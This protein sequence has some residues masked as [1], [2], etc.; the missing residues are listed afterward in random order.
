MIWRPYRDSTTVGSLGSEEGEIVLDEEGDGGAR[1]TLENPAKPGG[2]HTI[3]CGIYGAM[4]HT[5]FFG[6]EDEA[7]KAWEPM[8]TELAAL[9]ALEDA[10][11][12]EAACSEFCERWL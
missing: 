1:V 8:K 9:R 3:T 10:S 4:V 11:A 6:D 5:A 12:F 7:R 2:P